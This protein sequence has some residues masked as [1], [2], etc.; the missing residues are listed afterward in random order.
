MPSLSWI[1]AFTFSTSVFDAVAQLDLER[2]GLAREGFDEDLHA[3]AQAEH[4]V[5]RG[6]LLDVVVR[7]RAAVFQLLA[8]ED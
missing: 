3:T 5:Q 7:Q 6:L 1:L 8:G 2:D 4:Q